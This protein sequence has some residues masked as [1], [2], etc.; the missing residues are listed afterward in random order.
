MRL[1]ASFYQFPPQ[2]QHDRA[3]T[4]WALAIA[5]LFAA[6]AALSFAVEQSV[7]LSSLPVAPP[8]PGAAHSR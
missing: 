3:G 8:G 5:I 4:L 6:V 1:G 2:E 7:S